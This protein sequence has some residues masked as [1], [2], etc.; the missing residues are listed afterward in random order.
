LYGWENERKYENINVGWGKIKDI[1]KDKK[2]IIG[3]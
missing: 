2:K 3:E 1:D